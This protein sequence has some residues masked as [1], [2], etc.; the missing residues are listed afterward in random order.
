MRHAGAEFGFDFFHAGLRAFESH[1]AAQFFG[2]ASGEVGGDHGEAQQ[3]FL[4]KRNAERALQH[5]FERGMGIGDFF[6]SLAAL[7]KWIHH[8][9]D[10]GA[11]ADDRDLHHDVVK[12]LRTQARQARHLRAAFHLK[13]AHGVGLLQRG[14]D[15]RVIL[16]KMRQV[17]FL[18]IVIANEFDGIFEHGHHAEAE[19]SRL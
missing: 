14:I 10:D 5:G 9:A 3:L 16:R 18:V 1:G 4:K 19:Q 6:A 8:L 15:R 7:Q 12:L 2:F 17:D 11:G 13:Q